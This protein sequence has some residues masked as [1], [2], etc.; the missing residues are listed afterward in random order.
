[1]PR[2]EF[3]D[4]SGT[5]DNFNVGS[6]S[7]TAQIS[8]VEDGVN[9]TLSITAGTTS[10]GAQQGNGFIRNN[11]DS[12]LISYGFTSSFQDLQ[13][14]LDVSGGTGATVQPGTQFGDGSG[15]VTLAI[16]N[17]FVTLNGS[18]VFDGASPTTFPVTSPGGSAFLQSPGQFTAI[19]FTLNN[20]GNVGAG[21]V[22]FRITFFDAEINCFCAGTRIAT[23]E[24]TCPV[25]ELRAGDLVRLACGRD[26]AVRWLGRQRVE[27]TLAAPGKVNPI[28]ITK[29]ALG[30][31]LP[32][33]DLRLSPDHAIA[34]DGFLINAGALINGTTIYQE[35]DVREDFTYYHIETNAHEL[36]LAEGVTA[37]TFID[38]TT[39][40]T[41]E[42]AHEAPDRMIQEM[43]LPRISSA[44][45]VPHHIKDRLAP[46]L[47]AE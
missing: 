25:E 19:K 22:N 38:Y 35:R 13:V 43:P 14:T 30:G 33:R 21:S 40:D 24:G 7:S 39:R 41:F 36:L 45:L 1:M 17:A 31:D 20:L 3:D 37:E 9:F 2:F 10:G 26:V 44:R 16:N 6:G 11:A 29:G 18:V 42:N 23:P 5:F 15:F 34:I 47:A 32:E 4:A 12:L 27:P 28:R 46:V 8:F